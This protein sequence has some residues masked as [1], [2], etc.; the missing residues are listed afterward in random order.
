V[1]FLIVYNLRFCSHLKCILKQS[2]QRSF[3]LKQH[4][5]Q[6]LTRKQ[7]SVVFEAI[8]V[9]R[10][11]YALPA[12]SGFLTKDAWAALIIFCVACS[13]TDIVLSVS[14]SVILSP[15]VMNNYLNLYLSHRIV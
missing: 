7:L 5:C 3:I 4:R 8:I 6:G 10:L 13:F 1:L 9:S 14:M 2:S 11:R 12:W 15:V